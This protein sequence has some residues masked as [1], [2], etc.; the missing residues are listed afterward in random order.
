MS[1]GLPLTKKVLTPLAKRVLVSLE[2]TAAASAT[3]AAIQMKVYGS[4]TTALIFSKEDVN[5]IVQFIKSLKKSG[6]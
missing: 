2:L 6:L 1:V 4:G 3:D 5:G